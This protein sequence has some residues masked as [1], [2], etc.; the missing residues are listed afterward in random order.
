MPVGLRTMMLVMGYRQ[1]TDSPAIQ[2]VTHEQDRLKR[3]DIRVYRAPR[4]TITLRL[5]EN[6]HE[7]MGLMTKMMEY[8]L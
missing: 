4:L 3:I 1:L 7:L 6:V 8:P 5:Q 2:I